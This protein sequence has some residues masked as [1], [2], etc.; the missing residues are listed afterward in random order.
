MTAN[1]NLVHAIADAL[2]EAHGRDATEWLECG[3]REAVERGVAG[4]RETI[5]EGAWIH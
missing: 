4:W 5:E 3:G 1:S 2:I